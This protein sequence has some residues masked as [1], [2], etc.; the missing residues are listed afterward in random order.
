MSSSANDIIIHQTLHGY[1]D[2]H[3]LLKSSKTLSK[4]AER[5][6]LII[7]DM[8]GPSMIPG[9]ETYITGYSLTDTGWYALA[10]TWYAPEMERPG[11]VWT[12]TLLIENTDL[13]RIVDLNDLTTLFARPSKKSSSWNL[14]ESPQIFLRDRMPASRLIT[15]KCANGVWETLA[16]YVISALYASPDRPVYIVTQRIEEYEDLALT[17]WSQQWPRLRRNFWFCTGSITNRKAGDK[18]FDLQT[19]PRSSVSHIKR[20][21]ASAIIVD[22]GTSNETTNFPDWVSAAVTDLCNPKH[23]DLRRFLKLF[24]SETTQGRAD[25]PRLTETFLVY[26]EV[27]KGNMPLAYLTETISKHF[28]EPQDAARLKITLFG[29]ENNEAHKRLSSVP[30]APESDLLRELITT[31]H[32]SALDMNTLGIRQRANLLIEREPVIASELAYELVGAE[33]TPIGNEFLAGI[34]DGTIATD[35]SVLSKTKRGILP[36]LLKH[37]PS[38]IASLQLWQGNAYE[39]RESFDLITSSNDFTN[40]EVDELISAMIDAGSDAVAYEVEYKFGIR[41]VNAVLAWCD[42]SSTA[43]TLSLSKR[44]QRMLSEHPYA[45]LR[46]LRREQPPSTATMALIAS[47]L[48]PHS[49]DVIGSGANLW[50]HLAETASN[51]LDYETLVSTMTFLLTLGFNN[52][53]R[54]ASW[55]VAQSFEIVHNAAERNLLGH[56]WRMLDY[57]APA[58]ADWRTWDKCER[59][60]DALVQNFIR[61]KWPHEHLLK[62]LE[63]PRTLVQ[64]LDQSMNVKRH[65]KYI[66]KVAKQVVEGSV[67]ATE[68]QRRVLLEYF[69][70]QKR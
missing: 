38:L 53:S 67:K 61:F 8:S 1:M 68:D 42:K 28:P 43:T 70:S 14:Y 7:S 46:W 44:W 9:F 12:H 54:N 11:C 65:R 56:N 15:N 48:D 62:S 22:R 29:D 60:R 47:L 50:V 37:K 59:L 18:P 6:M 64:V 52:H 69:G 25:F 66:S 24:G 5:M 2:G 16:H 19:V 33:L 26:K 34:C 40:N 32:Y 17:I 10:K 57:L 49:A 4:E 45:L 21:I 63:Y 27:R 20:E 31:E 23:K 3:R 51:T 58:L 41:A 13:A 39:Q 36:L 30:T 35:P 55:L